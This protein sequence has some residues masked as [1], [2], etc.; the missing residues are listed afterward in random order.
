MKL[1]NGKRN[2]CFE[3]F[4]ALVFSLVI[5]YLSFA[6]VITCINLFVNRLQAGYFFLKLDQPLFP[7]FFK[8]TRHMFKYIFD[9]PEGSQVHF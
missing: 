6:I 4:L 9:L 3:I 1:I 8:L 2:V 7:P 5:A